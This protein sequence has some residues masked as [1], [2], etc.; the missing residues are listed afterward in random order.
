MTAI[1]PETTNLH[2]PITEE[3]HIKCAAPDCGYAMHTYPVRSITTGDDG[4]YWDRLNTFWAEQFHRYH[5]S[6]YD[7]GRAPDITVDWEIS[8][9]CSVCEDGIGK[10]VHNDSETVTCEECGTTWFMDGTG[11]EL[12]DV[13]A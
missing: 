4:D 6:Q 5:A 1:A 12:K 10:V 3:H 7:E 13:D 8:A 11:G 9:C 2:Q